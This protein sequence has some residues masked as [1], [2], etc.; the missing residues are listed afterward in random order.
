MIEAI[1]ICAMSMP[2]PFFTMPQAAGHYVMHSEEDDIKAFIR[3]HHPEAEIFITPKGQTDKLREYGWERLPFM[4]R[5][6]EIW[7]QRKPRS[8]SP[9]KKAIETSA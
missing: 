2:S 4:W 9:I 8:D 6:M 5:N 7:I 3:K 1:L